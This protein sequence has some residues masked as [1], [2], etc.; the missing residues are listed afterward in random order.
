MF[1]SGAAVLFSAVSNPPVEREPL[2]SAP[3]HRGRGFCTSGKV[4]G[5]AWGADTLSQESPPLPPSPA[6]DSEYY[7]G[8][9]SGG[10]G[11]WGTG[12]RAGG[13]LFWTALR[14]GWPGT[15]RRWEGRLRRRPPRT[16][17]DVD[18]KAELEETTDPLRAR[19][20]ER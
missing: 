16:G 4:T 8:D 1:V 15:R 14:P 13:Y 7:S 17:R 9:Q 19:K 11:A 12:L 6:M 10:L 18:S 5:V 2:S 20:L 3:R